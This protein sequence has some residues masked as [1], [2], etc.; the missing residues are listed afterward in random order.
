[1]TGNALKPDSRRVSSLSLFFSQ[2]T[3]RNGMFFAS[4]L[5]LSRPSRGSMAWQM[6]TQH[7]GLLSSRPRA[8]G[9]IASL[10]N[11]CSIWR[12]VILKS[13]NIVSIWLRLL[14]ANM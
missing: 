14:L 12:A 8:V 9:L 13:R 6:S 10:P 7:S 2:Y 1:M 4:A 3:E 11:C 5:E